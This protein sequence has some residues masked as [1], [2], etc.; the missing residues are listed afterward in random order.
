M[1]LLNKHLRI[2]EIWL[3]RVSFAAY[4]CVLLFIMAGLEPLLQIS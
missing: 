3:I 2:G 1:K 4:L